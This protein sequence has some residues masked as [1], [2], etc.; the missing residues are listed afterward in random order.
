MS[1]EERKQYAILINE[2]SKGNDILNTALDSYKVLLEELEQDTLIN[3]SIIC[4][5]D[6]NDNYNNLKSVYFNI[7]KIINSINN[8][9]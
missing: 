1:D 8:K 4:H 2:L 5:E 3:D 6:F 7:N 9:I